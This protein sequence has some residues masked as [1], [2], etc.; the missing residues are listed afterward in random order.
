MP[1]IFSEVT[2]SRACY[3]EKECPVQQGD[4]TCVKSPA[5]AADLCAG[6]RIANVGRECFTYAQ[7]VA[8]NKGK[9]IPAPAYPGD[10][11]GPNGYRRLL[12]PAECPSIFDPVCGTD[13]KTYPNAC[14]AK[15]TNAGYKPGVCK[16]KRE[17]KGPGFKTPRGSS[18]KSAGTTS[19]SIEISTSSTGL[20]PVV[21]PTVSS[22]PLPSPTVAPTAVPTPN[23]LFRL[24]LFGGISCSP[25]P[26][27]LPSPVPTSVVTA[28]PSPTPFPTVIPRPT[29]T[30]S[31]A[32][33][34]LPTFVPTTWP[35]PSVSV[36]PTAFPTAV[37]TWIPTASPTATPTA[38]PKVN[39]HCYGFLSYPCGIPPACPSGWTTIDGTCIQGGV[40]RTCIAPPFTLS[41]IDSAG[42]TTS[43]CPSGYTGSYVSSVNPGDCR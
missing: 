24:P 36:A 43:K 19:V 1:P 38:I 20:P 16:P 5:Y 6:Y 12:E 28:V 26:V 18:V 7:C 35:R 9:C 13:G 10:K 42:A 11:C 17:I 25:T 41:C 15:K 32:P 8:F 14:E 22:V 33:T 23:C 39:L 3:S 40:N 30:P 37:P 31:V 21:V 27:P 29:A 2:Y 34:V 4:A